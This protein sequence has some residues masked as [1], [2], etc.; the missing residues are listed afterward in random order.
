M[1]SINKMATQWN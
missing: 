1:A